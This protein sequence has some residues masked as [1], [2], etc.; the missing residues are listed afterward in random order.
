MIPV[1]GS[2]IGVPAE[3]RTPVNAVAESEDSEIFIQ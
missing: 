2:G 1:T 3:N